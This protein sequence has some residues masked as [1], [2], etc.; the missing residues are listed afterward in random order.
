VLHFSSLTDTWQMRGAARLGYAGSWNVWSLHGSA[1]GW[2]PAGIAETGARALLA[3][4]V[5]DTA[6]PFEHT[7][8]AVGGTLNADG[9]LASRDLSPTVLWL[10]SGDGAIRPRH[11][12]VGRGFGGWLH[13]CQDGGANRLYTCAGALDVSSRHLEEPAALTGVALGVSPLERHLIPLQSADATLLVGLTHVLISAAAGADLAPAADELVAYRYEVDEGGGALTLEAKRGSALES[14]QPGWGI[15]L[16]RRCARG[17]STGEVTMGARVVGVETRSDGLRITAL[18]ALGELAAMRARR[19]LHFTDYAFTL[20]HAAQALVAWAGLRVDASATLDGDAPLFQWQGGESGL[21]ALR[22]LLRDVPVTLRSRVDGAGNALQVAILDPD[23]AVAYTYGAGAHPLIEHAVQAEATSPRL[24]VVHGLTSRN[25]PSQGEDW[26]L[27]VVGGAVSPM[28]RARPLYY[29]NRGQGQNEQ[30]ATAAGL[31]EL[32]R[33]R[34]RAGWFD[35]QAN[36]ALEIGD[37]VEV[38]GGV[39]RVEGIVEEWRERRLVQRVTLGP[40]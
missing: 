27:E 6:Y 4:C 34:R 3:L 17:A 20:Q 7:T 8:A 38:E 33:A 25:D 21:Q 2:L 29:L 12:A 37:C 13:T 22:R 10:V 26:A 23:P 5:A 11:Q 24:V 31:A 39:Y 16:T 1:T 18:D 28:A 36:L 30:P 15:W 19:P 32:V 40:G 14:A 35:A 9:T